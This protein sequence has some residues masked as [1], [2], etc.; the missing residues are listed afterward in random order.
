M[1]CWTGDLTSLKQF[2][3]ANF[4]LNGKWKSPGDERKSYSDGKTTITWWRNKK[5]LHFYGKDAAKLKQKC[6]NLLMGN[7][8][9]DDNSTRTNRDEHC[10]TNNS[11]TI[12]AESSKAV[13]AAKSTEKSALEIETIN[14]RLCN[15]SLHDVNDIKLDIEMLQSKT[16]ALQSLANV[17]EGYSSIID[18]SNKIELLEQGC[19][20]ERE[21]V[22]KIELDLIDIK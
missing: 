15:R 8:M 6:C 3:E 10:R 22:N 11:C 19:L 17:Q 1:L 5:K 16:D 2:I 14:H 13:E 4:D 12:I 7:E 21:K 20:E 9:I 18:N